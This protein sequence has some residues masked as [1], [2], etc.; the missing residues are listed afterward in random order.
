MKIYILKTPEVLRPKSQKFNYP[1]HNSDYGVE[2]DFY[3]FLQA[4]QENLTNSP[5]EAD[6]HY[7]PVYWTRWHLNHDYGNLGLQELQGY[8]DQVILEDSKTFTICQYDDGPIIDLGKTVQFLSSR[9]TLNGIDIPLLCK[10]H[11]RPWFTQKKRYLASFVGRIKTHPIRL[12]MYKE[13]KDSEAIFI[14]DGNMP[15]RKFVRLLL[16]SYLALAPRGYG[17]SS[18]RLFEA[19][20]LGVAPILLGD[21]DTRPFKQF[22]PWDEVSKYVKNIPELMD[23][24]NK[25]SKSELLIMGEKSEILFANNLT[26]QKW[27]PY[28]FKELESIGR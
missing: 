14:Q 2:Q 21:L 15:T 7:L 5:I 27:C 20:Q 4:N 18:F 17:G 11:A 19:M 13:L 6:W 25:R 23:F 9:K 12:Q 28:V 16:Q 24:L 26:Y 22:L 8:V 3:D 1:K 10:N